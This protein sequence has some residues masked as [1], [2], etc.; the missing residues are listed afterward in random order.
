MTIIGPNGT[1]KTVNETIT[2]LPYVDLST[3][4]SSDKDIYFVEDIAIWTITVHNAWNGTNAT[5][6]KL[7][8]SLP[9][10]FEFIR[11]ETPNG[12]YDNET[13]IWDIGFMG[14]GTDATL[15]IWARAIKTGTNIT[16]IVN[17]SC[18]E[19]EWNYTNN[20]ANKSVDVIPLPDPFKNV[21]NSTPYYHDE[22]LYYLTINNTGS[23]IYENVLKVIDSL[24]EG[25]EY[26][27]Y[28]ITGAE[29]DGDVSI[30]G[31][32]ITWN[33]T[34][35]P[36]NTKAVITVKVKVN[37]L[38]NLTNN[39]T[40]I[41]PNGSNQ[42][43][44]ATIDP[45]PIVDLSTNKTSDKDK[46]FVDDIVI[47]T[48][49]V[50]N[51]YNGTN[52]SEVILKDKIPEQ[53]EFINYTATKGTYD[54]VTGIWN[55]SF[56]ENGTN[57]TL[58]IR[59]IARVAIDKITNT[60]NVTCAEKDWN[61][62]NNVDNETVKIIPLP[63]PVKTVSNSTP[64]YHD[65]VEYNLTIINT[66]DINYTNILTVVDSLPEGLRFIER[67]GIEGCVIIS[68]VIGDNNVTWQIT[69]I[70]ANSNATIKVK[71]RVEALG[72]LT[73]N[74][75][76]IGPEGTNK[77][78]NATVTPV[79]IV[80]LSTNKT[81][82]KDE[83]F[84]DDIAVWTITV[85]NAGN[86]TN[87]TNVTLVDHIPTQFVFINYTATNGTYNYTTGIWTIGFMGNG[88]NATLTIR[89]RAVTPIDKVTNFAKV[90]CTE[91]EWN[92][93]NNE[94]NK[95][96]TIF[97][98]PDPQKTVSNL[99]PYNRDIVLYN[100]TITNVGDTAYSNVL[101]VV[102][103]LPE[104][105]EFVGTEGVYG[106]DL[107]EEIVDGKKITWTITNISAKSSAVISLKV[108]VMDIGN[109]TN[110]L[111]IVGPF[112]TNKTVNCTIDPVPI[113]DLE[114]TKIN[115]YSTKACYNG[116]TVTWTISVINNGPNDAINS[117]ASDF[118]PAGLIY[119]SDDSNGTYDYETGIWSIG[120][121]TV[122][123]SVTLTIKTLVNTSN[124]T[125]TNYVNVTSDTHD[126]D[127]SNNEDNSSVFIE[128][129]ADLEIIKIV[130][131]SS[132]HKGDKVTW[133][134]IVTN[135]GPDAALNTVVTDKLPR[136]LVYISD[137]SNGAYDPNTGI[138]KVGNLASGKSATIKIVSLVA[139]TNK[140]ITNVAMVDSDTYDPNKT[141]NKANNSTV[142]PPEVDLVLTIEPNVTQVTVGDRVG[143]TVTVVN[144]GP[145]TA[146]NSR[147]YIV[148]PDELKLL[149]FKPSKGTYN[150]KTGIWIIGDLAPGEEVTLTLD[151]K[152]LA[153]GRFVVKGVVECDT[154][155]T[156]YTNN[157]DSAI[158]DVIDA[159]VPSKPPVHT[160]IP[161]TKYPTGN[162]IVI[163]LL[164]VLVI[165]GMALR[166]KS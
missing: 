36:A 96:V 105:L 31:Q 33:I 37:A 123:S 51:A 156:D 141:N 69:N 99:T 87:A 53:F 140:N 164:S 89:T 35:I 32:I 79:P 20:I 117:I 71:V 77:T 85:H 145:D 42:T 43:V 113:A 50:H 129:E 119:V 59:S 135:H 47:W 95:T 165:V 100:L 160:G 3:L 133:T 12:E 80:D 150:P 138:W 19:D 16:N 120:N 137:N 39:L 76:V 116:D 83:Y 82:D 52:A 75:T 124:V 55:I 15:R 148:I 57:A 45:V 146:V 88:T 112:G 91:D 8:E 110:N 9:E 134:L 130:S 34:N 128:P 106:A 23:V 94:A 136:G 152:A 115:D 64:Y 98:L 162:P 111:T 14:N 97:D 125:I 107:I 127:E 132:V 49:T 84:V 121:L 4:K 102:D 40:I 103:S 66:G 7:I 61:L 41:G 166:R 62:S 2:P 56:M 22:V 63:D 81:S 27:G 17:V 114:V 6:V 10:E 46:Y 151:T 122:G 70:S 5:H 144:Q 139:T 155:E 163:A 68:E 143:F 38:G 11:A 44:N 74:Q 67:I 72:N 147:A 93:T 13:K 104:G 58:T 109:Q 65:I 86:G 126:P 29:V 90:N 161:L 60:A 18:A 28:T 54:N 149:G 101:T 78:V 92:L 48:I 25:L 24:P 154:F 131:N 108:L 158:V 153:T 26:I 21:S 30:D 159:P 157:N 118:L 73:N 1:N 142:V